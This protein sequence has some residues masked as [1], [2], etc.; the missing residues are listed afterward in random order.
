MNGLL[1]LAA[2]IA[3]TLALL[4]LLKLRGPMFTF[5][6][7]F[8]MLGA[9]GYALQ[10]RPGLAGAADPA[11]SRLPPVPLTKARKALMGQFSAADTWITISEG[12]ASRGETEDAVGVMNSAIRARPGDYEMWV[13]LGNALADH[14]RTLTPAARFAFERAAALAPGHPAPMFFLG[15]AEARSGQPQLAAARWRAILASA[16]A[17]ASW[18]PL[19]QDALTALGGR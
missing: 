16:P 4:W 14:A 17:N 6:A 1:I 2:L 13:G 19:V 15:L 9:S 5:A 18:R 12:Y 11:T 8:L 3:A 10:G 7:A